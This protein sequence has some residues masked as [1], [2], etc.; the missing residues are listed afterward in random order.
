MAKRKLTVEPV[1]NAPKILQATEPQAQPGAP[2]DELPATGLTR[3]VG[4]G[5]KESE[6]AAL[7]E[8]AAATGIA[9]PIELRT[10]LASCRARLHR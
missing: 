1:K 9:M 2:S 3:P 4:I 8:I 6:Y 7:R 10:D 5:L